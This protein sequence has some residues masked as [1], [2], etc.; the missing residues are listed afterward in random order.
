MNRYLSILLSFF[1]LTANSPSGQGPQTI[2]KICAF[3]H[4][5]GHHLAV[6]NEDIS[7]L[8]FIILHYS[9]HSHHEEDHGE[10]E[11]LPFQHHHHNDQQ[12]FTQQTPCLLP[13]PSEIVAIPNLDIIPSQ[14]NSTV[15]QWPCTAYFCSIWQPP[16][17]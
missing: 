11:N 17:V 13:A 4:H 7:I 1:I 12:T 15:Q 8:D 3:I 14:L 10:H 16:R 6:H 2:F 5:F 9:E